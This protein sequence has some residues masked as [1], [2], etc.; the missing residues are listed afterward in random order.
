[1]KI[2]PTIGPATEKGKDLKYLFN[3]C[4]MARLNTSHNNISWHKKMINLIKRL[5][6]NIDILVD[7][8]GVKPRTDNKKNVYLKKNSVIRFGYKIKK[9]GVK[10]YL[11]N[12]REN[13][14][15]KKVLLIIF[16]L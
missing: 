12:L 10:R 7:I 14:H 4:S 16:F 3:Y 9:K 1:M 5:D 6:K 15:L 8:P 11:L 2:L 13:F